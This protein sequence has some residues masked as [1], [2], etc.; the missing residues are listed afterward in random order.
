LDSKKAIGLANVE[1]G[2]VAEVD[3]DGVSIG[4][5]GGAVRV[6]KFK[7]E[8]A[9]KMSAKEFLEHY[10]IELGARFG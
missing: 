8:G 2:S 4:C 9:G 1:P 5:M 3:A 7:P 10:R 6:E